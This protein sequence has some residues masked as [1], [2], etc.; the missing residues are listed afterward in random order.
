MLFQPAKVLFKSISIVSK[1]QWVYC[2]YEGLK[3]MFTLWNDSSHGERCN[4]GVL[5]ST[6]AFEPG[7]GKPLLTAKAVHRTTVQRSF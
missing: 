1:N 6:L 2:T 7:A 4:R 5:A 3:S